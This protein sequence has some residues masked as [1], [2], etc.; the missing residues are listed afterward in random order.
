M[1]VQSPL[2][3]GMTPHSQFLYCH[4]AFDFFLNIKARV[5]P[6]KPKWQ[7]TVSLLSYVHLLAISLTDWTKPLQDQAF[8]I[9]PFP[10]PS[11]LLI[12]LW[13]HWPPWCPLTGSVTPCL[14]T[15]VLWAYLLSC[16]VSMWFITKLIPGSNYIK[17]VVLHS[18]NFLALFCLVSVAFI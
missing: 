1:L 18:G 17:T 6:F 8:R 13:P 7:H 15:V 11:G 4:P 12:L 14:C 16:Q 10:V 3:H 5:K 2:L 9:W